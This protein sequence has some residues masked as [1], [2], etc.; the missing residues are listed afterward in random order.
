MELETFDC[1]RCGAS[2]TQVNE[3]TYKC[4]YCGKVYHAKDVAES[5]KSFKEMF[6]ASKREHI[7][8]L[9]RNLYEA[10][11]AM[12]ISSKDVEACA[13]ELKHEIKHVNSIRQRHYSSHNMLYHQ[14]C[15][16]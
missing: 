16:T 15:N 9:R 12:F 2:L 11:N 6:D 10:T 1:N 14:D 3:D 7:N 13:D 4:E 5:T 8:N